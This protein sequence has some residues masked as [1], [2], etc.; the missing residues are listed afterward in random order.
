MVW[1][2]WAPFWAP[3][4]CLSSC[5]GQRAPWNP[6]GRSARPDRRSVECRIHW[7]QTE[8]HPADAWNTWQ[9]IT[10]SSTEESSK[11]WTRKWQNSGPLQKNGPWWKAQSKKTLPYLVWIVRIF[12][13][14]CFG[15]T[16]G[17][18]KKNA[19]FYKIIR[20]DLRIGDR[21]M[22][23]IIPSILLWNFRLFGH[24]VR[25]EKGRTKNVQTDPW[26][27]GLKGGHSGHLAPLSDRVTSEKWT[28]NT[29]VSVNFI[30]V[31]VDITRGSEIS[32][33]VPVKTRDTDH[34]LHI[35]GSLWYEKPAE[36]SEWSRY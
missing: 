21:A 14:G 18:P 17:N 16:N 9:K 33:K 3:R 12:G 24:V 20:D 15:R 13:E 32:R 5:Q 28:N 25:D 10:P 1:A 35:R 34:K 27:N 2:L 30:F 23:Q 8:R 29:S 36:W 19:P 4:R 11:L 22:E 7:R 31:R 26:T 6:V